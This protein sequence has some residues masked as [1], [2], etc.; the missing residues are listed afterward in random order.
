MLC[1]FLRAGES[2]DQKVEPNYLIIEEMV[3]ASK[4]TILQQT[5]KTS[6]LF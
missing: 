1:S 5:W 4:T 2:T 6:F 3:I